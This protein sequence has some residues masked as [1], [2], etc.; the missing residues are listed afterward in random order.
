MLHLFGLIYMFVSLSIVC[1]EFFVPSLEVLTEKFDI[2]SD[3]SGATFMAAGG[4]APEFFTS[5]I[6][7][8]IANNNVGI[9]TIVGSATFNI[10]CVLAFCTLFSTTV[11]HLTW[12]PLFRDVSFYIVSLFMLVIFFMDEKIVWME[13][14]ALFIVYLLYITFMKFNVAIESWVKYKVLKFKIEVDESIEEE[15]DLKNGIIVSKGNVTENP[16]NNN[17]PDRPSAEQITGHHEEFHHHHREHHYTPNS[18]QNGSN[19]GIYPLTEGE[20][21]EDATSTGN[22]SGGKKQIEAIVDENDTDLSA[23]KTTIK[24]QSRDPH[25]SMK[26]DESSK[27]FGGDRRSTRGEI[28]ALKEILEDNEP[29]PLDMSWPNEWHKQALYLFLAP[30]L[31]PLWVTIP[32]VRKEECRKWYPATF[33]LSILWIAGFSYLMVWWA[34]TIGETF[35]LPTEIIGLTILAAGTSIPDLITSVIVARKG[36]GDMAVSSSIG[37]NIFDVSI[38]MPVPWLLWFGKEAILSDNPVTFISVSSNGLICS[39]GMLFVMLIVLV[40]AIAA[41]NWQMNKLFGIV[42][43]ISYVIFCAF[44][45]A[46]EMRY[47]ECPLKLC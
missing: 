32:D 12:W 39:V 20:N 38:G 17:F 40:I 27:T 13:A 18:Y 19:V 10:L 3:I 47:I 35:R 41:S 1:D 34:N 25:H 14:L 7:V 6:G 21:S 30:I 9:G 44:S 37:S 46:L 43:I 4:S 26:R 8:F 33:I 16:L 22:N 2:S 24:N 23:V 31:M 45:V 11:L 42:M 36:L 28:D 5:V 29:T 15:E